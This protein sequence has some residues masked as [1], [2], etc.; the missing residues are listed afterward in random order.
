MI[1][2]FI[3][4]EGG[5]TLSI[6]FSIILYYFGILFQLLFIY[7]FSKITFMCFGRLCQ[8]L[9]WN[10]CIKHPFAHLNFC[11]SGQNNRRNCLFE[12]EQKKKM[13]KYLIENRVQGQMGNRT[14]NVTVLS[15]KEMYAKR[16]GTQSRHW[17]W[18]YCHCKKSFF[19]RIQTKVNT[20]NE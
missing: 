19:L 12:Y 2:I 20:W 10:Q 8:T 9:Y 17:T 7:F 18:L 1:I 16:A 4:N 15:L 6:A 13:K 5:I 11:L 3:L 14:S